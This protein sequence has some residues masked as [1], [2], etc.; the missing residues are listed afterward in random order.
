MV[1]SRLAVARVRAHLREA[2]RLTPARP[3]IA[4]GARTAIATALPLVAAPIIGPAAATWASVAG[5]VVALADKG[6]AYPTRAANMGAVT[7]A[8]ALAAVVGGL[9]GG[10]AAV[11]I[12]TMAL[13]TGVCGFVGVYG[14]L[15]AGVG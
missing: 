4:L 2:L 15:A 11:A 6:G 12:V 7:L 13:W 1:Q 10:H 14:P 9:V 3:A 5:F 8:G